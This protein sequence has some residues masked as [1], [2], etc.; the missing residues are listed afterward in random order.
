[1]GHFKTTGSPKR[2]F[3][4]PRRNSRRKLEY[5]AISNPAP[6]NKLMIMCLFHQR[7]CFCCLFNNSP[8]AHHVDSTQCYDTLV[9]EPGSIYPLL[10]KLVLFLSGKKWGII[11]TTSTRLIRRTR[12]IIVFITIHFNKHLSRLFKTLTLSYS[13]LPYKAVCRGVI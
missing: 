12:L 11:Q 4:K 7:C 8:F 2:K 1:M 3:Y 6:G 5:K 13:G 9:T 10:T